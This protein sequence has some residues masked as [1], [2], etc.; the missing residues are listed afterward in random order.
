MKRIVKVMAVVAG[1]A[2]LVWAMRDRFVSI[3][4]PKEP[5]PPTFRVAPPQPPR[6]EATTDDDLTMLIGVGPV[7]AG[8]LRTAGITTFAAVAQANPQRLAAA[9]G[10]P[11]SRVAAWIEQAAVLRFP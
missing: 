7:Y 11:M 10:V 3:S 8:R 6:A 5:A 1:L 9:A 2:G 4:A